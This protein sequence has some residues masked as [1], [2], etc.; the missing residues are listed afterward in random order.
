MRRRKNEVYP[1]L[2]LIGLLA[3]GALAAFQFYSTEGFVEVEKVE[4]FGTSVLLSNG[5]RGLLAATTAERAES[6]QNA[7]AGTSE[8]RPNAHDT[9]VDTVRHFNITL[10]AVQLTHVEGDN[11]ISE[12]ILHQG[13]NV[14]KLDTRPSDAIAIALRLDAKI[15]INKTL[16]T[17]QGQYIC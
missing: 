4:V 9:F 8:E 6:I 11:F 17:E 2:I 14:L 5:C 3:G 15:Y 13:N 16:L 12:M 10:E 1:I 7:L